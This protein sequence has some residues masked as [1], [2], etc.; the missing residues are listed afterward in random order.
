MNC[1]FSHSIYY[2]FC[3]WIWWNI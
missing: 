2:L 1:I 3:N